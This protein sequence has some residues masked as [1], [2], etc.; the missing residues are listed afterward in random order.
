MGATA[1][2]NATEETTPGIKKSA[3]ITIAKAFA[4]S[5]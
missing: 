3:R 4:L 5:K 2:G 1:Y